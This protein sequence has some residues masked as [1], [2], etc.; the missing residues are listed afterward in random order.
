MVDI[1]KIKQE[2]LAAF[3]NAEPPQERIVKNTPLDAALSQF[4]NKASHLPK[5]LTFEAIVNS[6]AA[7]K[8]EKAVDRK[9]V[10]DILDK[11]L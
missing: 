2:L 3:S 4:F 9:Q 7:E 5:E 11:Y 8:T 10:R 6:L 1:K